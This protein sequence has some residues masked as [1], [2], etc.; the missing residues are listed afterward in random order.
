MKNTTLFAG[1]IGLLIVGGIVYYA[2]G[3]GTTESDVATTT[4][5]TTITIVKEPTPKVTI[6]EAGAPITTT[7]PY[8][9][10]SEF[11]A[12]VSGTVVPH[13]FFTNYWFE[14]GQTASLGSKTT[15]QN[16][17]SGYLT[18]TTPGYISGLAKNT[19][20]Y[21][22]LVAENGYDKIEGSQYTFHT[23]P[24]NP[25]PLGG[26]PTVKTLATNNI[27][28]TTATL[29]GEITP[30]Q[31]TTQYWFEYG[32]TSNLG[33]TTSFQTVN[34]NNPKTSVSVP[35]A[36]LDA[37]TNYYYRLNAQ[38]QWG[39]VNGITSNFK[40]GG[41]SDTSKPLADTNS[42]NKINSTSAT[43]RGIVNP[44]GQQTI[45]WFEYST[46]SLLGSILLKTTDHKSAGAGTSNVSFETGVL[47]LTSNT[48]YFYRIVAENTL[49]ITYGD[50]VSFKTK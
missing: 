37:F 10:T 44:N 2:V 15:V 31:S 45:Y 40:T 38:N 33:N 1:I 5:T 34:N 3:A 13:G 11:A 18:I 28:R 25:V 27:T 46:D 19:T 36:N 20:Y 23:D 26:L 16:I 7:S 29:N 30:N 42:A 22:R 4:P 6:Q 47:G 12:S 14:Y 21:F 39:T 41:P 48:T 50:R 9:T 49:G 32:K 35:I 17:G 8:V 24:G 43:L